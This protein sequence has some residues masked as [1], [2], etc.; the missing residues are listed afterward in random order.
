MNPDKIYSIFDFETDNIIE[1]YAIKCFNYQYKNNSVYQDY[2][3]YLNIDPADIA[4]IDKIPFLPIEFYK[5]H[6]E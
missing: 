4:T 3:D 6:G 1:E 2:V 5:S